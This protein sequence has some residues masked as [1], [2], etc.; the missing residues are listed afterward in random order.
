M[1]W[2][3]WYGAVAYANWRSAMNGKPLCYDRIG[4]NPPNWDCNFGAAGYR[5]P[6]EAEW[7]KA[8]RGGVA[9]R[10]FPWSD[11]DTIQHARANYSSSHNDSYDTSPTGGYHPTFDTGVPP[12]TSP[13]GYFAPNSY[14]LYDM[15]GNVNEWCN[16][17]YSDTYYSSSPY[18]NPHGPTDGSYR[19]LRGGNWSGLGRYCRCAFRTLYHTPAPR[20]YSDGFR[21]ALDSE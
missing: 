6:T 3:N 8:A 21:L 7:E 16:D 2:V 17:W 10:R 14:G 11:T 13:A 15:A 9:G 5:L 19:I 12:Y 1:M 4:E 20:Y 18:N